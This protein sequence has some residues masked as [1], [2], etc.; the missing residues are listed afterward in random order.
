MLA[1]EKSANGANEAAGGGAADCAPADHGAALCP[2]ACPSA[3]GQGAPLGADACPPVAGHGAP[4]DG[5]ACPAP[6]PTAGPGLRPAPGRGRRIVASRGVR[7]SG[8]S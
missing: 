6:A 5:A 4:P 8:L 7:S 2:D 1:W 3:P